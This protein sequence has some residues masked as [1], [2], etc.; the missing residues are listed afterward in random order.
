LAACGQNGPSPTEAPQ[1]AGPIS[2]RSASIPRPDLATVA[3]GSSGPGYDGSSDFL[4]FASELSPAKAL[5]AYVSQLL[6]AGYRDAGRQGAWRVFVD[7]SLTVWVRVGSAGPPTSLVVRFAT[8]GAAG[9]DDPAAH[10]SSAAPEP[11]NAAGTGTQ[12][13]RNA[14]NP[15][16]GV[17]S[18]RRPDPPHAAG[19]AGTGSPSG[20][21][22]TGGTSTG[23]AGTGAGHSA[24]PAG[25]A[26]A[27]GGT[28]HDTSGGSRS[29]P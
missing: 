6:D 15:T 11:A 20:G 29:R 16:D 5:A 17:T 28:S 12:S 13:I 8:T 7:S 9:Q 4:S 26:A 1:G 21:T 24:G 14:P 25:G 18:A 3:L 19:Q 23:P 10:S 22:A 27:G 2:S